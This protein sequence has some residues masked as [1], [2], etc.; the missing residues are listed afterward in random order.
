MAFRKLSILPALLGLLFLLPIGVQGQHLP[1][2]GQYMFNGLAINPAY[3]GSKEALSLNLMHRSQWAGFEGAP[4]TQ[5]FSG[6]GLVRK[7]NIGLGAMLVNDNIGLTNQFGAFGNFAYII[8]F[9]KRSG[10]FK[11]FRK[12]TSYN[13]TKVSKLS[14]GL[15]VG[16]SHMRNSWTRA[17]LENPEDLIFAPDAM[18]NWR[19]NIGAGI[20]Y[21][22]DL[23]YTGFSIPNLVGMRGLTILDDRS[24]STM[25][26]TLGGAFVIS[27][28][29]TIQPSVLLRFM[30]NLSRENPGI[31][32]TQYDLNANFNFR[33]VI[34]LG[35]SYRSQNSL[36]GLLQLQINDQLRLGYSY[37]WGMSELTRMTNGSHEIMLMYDFRFKAKV[38]HPQFF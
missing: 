27:E 9:K 2:L 7:K 18:L 23:F 34:W 17:I 8:D 19:P 28:D 25:L 37:E 1:Q 36:I 24:A 38:M 29:V 33:N 13:Q 20:Y 31:E 3:A 5:I 32:A 22:S 6:H 11:S 10:R 21:R 16:A 26:Y 14:L 4:T 12:F 35:A 15:Q 30:P